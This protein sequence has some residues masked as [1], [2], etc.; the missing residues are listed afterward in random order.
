MGRAFTLRKLLELGGFGAG[1]VL[2]AFGVVAIVMGFNG[3]GTVGDNLALEGIT[4]SPDMTP[5]AIQQEAKQAGLKNITFPTCTVAGQVVDNGDRARCFASY[6]R[7]HA[8][9]A[10]GGFTYAQMG[11]LQ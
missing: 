9:E 5:A 2:I 8:L 11:R 4:G 6:M 3:R 7:I 10:T 1:A